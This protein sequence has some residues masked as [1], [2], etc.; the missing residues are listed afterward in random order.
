[1]ELPSKELLN[2]IFDAKI[3][4]IKQHNKKE[5]R[6]LRIVKDIDFGYEIRTGKAIEHINIYELMHLMKLWAFDKGFEI[7]ERYC[8]TSILNGELE[9]VHLVEMYGEDTFSPSRVFHCCEWIL[10]ETK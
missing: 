2:A 5:L 6:I 10:K 4:E 9:E 1:M 8:D 7:V 3:L